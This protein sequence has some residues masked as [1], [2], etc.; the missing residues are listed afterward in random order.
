MSFPGL[1]LNILLVSNI[2]MLSARVV[3]ANSTNTRKEK[4][5]KMVDTR[6]SDLKT[7]RKQL[8]NIST[9]ERK[10]LQDLWK[11]HRNFFSDNDTL[12]VVVMPEQSIDEYFEN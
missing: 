1:H 8:N 6:R 12:D 2:V 11:M 4:R 10:R 5:K 7:I 3:A 9:E